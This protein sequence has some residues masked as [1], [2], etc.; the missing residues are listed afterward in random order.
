MVAPFNVALEEAAGL[1]SVRPIVDP[2]I[3]RQ[4]VLECRPGFDRATT[5][6]LYR[7][8]IQVLRDLLI[9][10]GRPPPCA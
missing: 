10:H 1:V 6:T 8:L 9:P 2:P 5:A 3:T 7:L 4:I